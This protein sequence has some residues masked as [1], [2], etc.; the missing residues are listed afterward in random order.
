MKKHGK[1]PEKADFKLLTKKEDEQL[2]ILLNNFEDLLAE[3]AEHYQ[4]HTLARY[5]MDLAQAFNEFYHACP[6]LKADD[7]VRDARLLLIL[8]VQKVLKRGLSLLGM[9][10]PEAM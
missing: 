7:E 3:A 4:P 8:E 10:A 1:T 5:L 6:I 2:I 9:E